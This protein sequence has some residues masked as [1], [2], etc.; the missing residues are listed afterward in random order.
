MPKQSVAKV[1]FGTILAVLSLL[2]Q[3]FG[4]FRA[5]HWLQNNAPLV[6][7]LL[8]DPITAWVVIIISLGLSAWGV[9]EVLQ[10]KSK[11]LPSQLPCGVTAVA[12]PGTRNPATS[13]ES[14][15]AG[16]SLRIGDEIHNYFESEAIAVQQRTQRSED[17]AIAI[18]QKTLEKLRA[19]LPDTAIAELKNQQFRAS[20]TWKCDGVLTA[21]Y[22]WGLNSENRFL[23]HALEQI[24]AHLR[25]VAHDLLVSV[26]RDSRLISREGQGTS[27]VEFRVFEPVERSDDAKQNRQAKVWQI[28]EDV[29]ATYDKLIHAARCIFADVPISQLATDLQSAS[30]S[31]LE[32]LRWHTGDRYR[33]QAGNPDCDLGAMTLAKVRNAATK[34]PVTAKNVTAE[35]QFINDA[36]DQI[37]TVPAA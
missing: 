33:N 17:I 23:D 20:V 32:Y 11:P 8:V 19:A 1:L 16:A 28:A 13:I 2:N 29:C 5:F 22:Q 21:F 3:A 30:N 37:F 18:D 31:G 10:F 4:W 34:I 7:Q 9:W 24:H 15:G 35:L 6:W 27:E 12:G 26:R 36:G 14:I 25:E